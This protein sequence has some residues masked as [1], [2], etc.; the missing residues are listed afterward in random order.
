MGEFHPKGPEKKTMLSSVF[1]YNV[2][3]FI[4]GLRFIQLVPSLI[5]KDII[6]PKG[7]YVQKLF[8]QLTPSNYKLY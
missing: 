8:I 3:L 7:C 6:F 1:A 4:K 2:E 5:F